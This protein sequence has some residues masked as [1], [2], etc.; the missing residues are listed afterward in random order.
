[1]ASLDPVRPAKKR[2]WV[3]FVRLTGLG[4]LALVAWVA[5]I[6]PLTGSVSVLKPAPNFG[7]V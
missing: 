1:M 4:F 7:V 2:W 6:S 5:F 3:I